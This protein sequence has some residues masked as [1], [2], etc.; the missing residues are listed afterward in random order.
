MN[1]GATLTPARA[2]TGPIEVAHATGLVP[3]ATAVPLVVTVH[4]LAFRRD[5]D[6]FTRFDLHRVLQ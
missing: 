6:K 3:C 4:D 1:V 2:V 5:P